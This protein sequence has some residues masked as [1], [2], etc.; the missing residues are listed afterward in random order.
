LDG[1]K[2]G[3]R[4]VR[5]GVDVGGTFTDIVLIDQQGQRWH[6]KVPSTP[7]DPSQGFLK[8]VHD[9][10]TLAGLTPDQVD[11]ILH[12]TTVA[13]N[14]VLQRRGAKISLI[15]TKGFEDLLEIGRQQRP[16][17][18]DLSVDRVPSLVPRNRCFST[19]ER[20]TANGETHIELK[21][22]E[23]LRAAKDAGKDVAAVAVCLLFAYKNPI[24]EALLEKHLQS[25][26]PSIHIS[27]SS[28]VLPE[29]REYE[30]MSTTTLD[31]Y[32]TPILS[33]YLHR[34]E[35]A[36]KSDGFKAPLLVM[37]SH[38]GL[39]QA[40]LA[41]KQAVR[42]LFSGLAGG[43][44]GG[45]YTSQVMNEK[46][47][48]TFD[49]GGTSTDVALIDEGK[50]RETSE[51]SVGGLPCRVPMVDVETVGAGGGSIAW[52][53]AG[54]ILRV[55]P[56]SAG[57]KPGPCCYDL[58]G[59]DV[60]VTDAN[61]VLGR[62][63][64]Q[65]FLGGKLSLKIQPARKQLRILSKRLNLSEE[66]CA[67]GI[68]RIV[69]A[70]MERAIRLVS[71][72]RG[73]DPR[74]FA[75]AAFGG[76]GPMHAWALAKELGIPR[77][78]IPVGPGLHSALGLLATHLRCDRSQS[79]LLP[80]ATPDFE[81]LRQVYEG[82]ESRTRRLILEQGVSA[83]QI[84]TQRLAD[85]RY[86]GQSYE[87]IVET[88]RGKLNSR[89]MK[90]LL[91]R[92]NSHHEQRYGYATPEAEVTIVNLRVVASGPK[93]LLK[94]AHIPRSATPHHPKDH[95]SVFFEEQ[96]AFVMTPIYERSSLGQGTELQG[97]AIIE[98]LDS[99][100][101]VHPGVKAITRKAGNIIL[102]VNK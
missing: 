72:Q 14:A 57:A 39:L 101:V 74:E 38:G 49:M 86:R 102:E 18:Y 53:D 40:S 33:T 23:A 55:G 89:W 8:G 64:P 34:L 60:T 78:I 99:T 46:N 15:T 51:G 36:L 6:V 59:T 73:F 76:A 79:V 2:Q 100:T 9:A 63:N 62:L 87:L 13:T 41:R 21:E 85:L 67:F 1:T 12:G 7:N 92:F 48:V 20:V 56:Q 44:L 19:R 77:V 68:I 96:R 95:R 47:L 70:N 93:P 5:I 31:A 65:Y 66:E 22:K 94:P 80:A 29:F 52:I 27:L 30:R 50:F 35:Q 28:E 83:K 58:G 10:L 61:L 25:L 82:L 84:R 98:Q 16:R 69:N 71:I 11:Y 17:L 75:L 4:K 26:Y 91:S 3:S 24:H 37:Q 88:P 81:E 54:G 32:V 42:L 45:L 43:T 97:P 90:N